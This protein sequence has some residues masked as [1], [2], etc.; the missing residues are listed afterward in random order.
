MTKIVVSYSYGGFSLS[1]EAIAAI[2]ARK[3][4]PVWCQG[5]DLDRHD[6]DLVAVV[7]ELGERANGDYAELVIVQIPG[8]QYNLLTYDGS[9]TVITPETYGWITA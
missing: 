7:E 4:E 5:I 3:G 9:E 1:E 2:E 8:N 6:P